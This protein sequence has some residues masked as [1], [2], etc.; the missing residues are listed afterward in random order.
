MILNTYY[1]KQ[2]YEMFCSSTT[3]Q[4]EP[5][6]AFLAT[7][8]TFVLLTATTTIKGNVM[9]RF[10]G[11]S[12]Y[13]NDPRCNVSATYIVYLVIIDSETSLNPA[14]PPVLSTLRFVQ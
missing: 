4:R 8:N 2:H 6:V 11:N 13:A 5:I 12:V 7:L 10:H 9:L 1:C 3:V 14:P